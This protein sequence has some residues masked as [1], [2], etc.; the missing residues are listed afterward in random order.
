MP[1]NVGIASILLVAAKVKAVNEN[2]FVTVKKKGLH[3]IVKFRTPTILYR[4]KSDETRM[5][6]RTQ[7]KIQRPI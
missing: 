5:F 7:T 2:S 3:F 4:P 6:N 1:T